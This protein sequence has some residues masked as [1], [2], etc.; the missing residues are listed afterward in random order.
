[1]GIPLGISKG[2]PMGISKGIQFR[3]RFRS[4]PIQV[5]IDFATIRFSNLDFRLSDSIPDSTALLGHLEEEVLGH[6]GGE[7]SGPPERNVQDRILVFLRFLHHLGSLRYDP[8]VPK[9]QP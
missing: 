5:V 1:M 9:V 3:F 6:F 7:L 4:D 8:T 2:I